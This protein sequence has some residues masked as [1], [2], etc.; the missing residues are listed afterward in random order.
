MINPTQ[1][2]VV[3]EI[4]S[5]VNPGLILTAKSLSTNSQYLLRS[6]HVP[7]L[8]QE[9]EEKNTTSHRNN[10]LVLKVFLVLHG[11][12]KFNFAFKKI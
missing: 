6:L 12:R 5:H 9:L 8:S 1:A 10:I 3:R 4:E 7:Q 2:T 11:K